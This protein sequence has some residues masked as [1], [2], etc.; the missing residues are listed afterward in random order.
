MVGNSS[1][2]GSV[3]CS[4]TSFSTSA[5]KTTSA[6]GL[7]RQ[8]GESKFSKEVSDSI[9]QIESEILAIK[10][11]DHLA[12]IGASHP[13]LIKKGHE[14]M[15]ERKESLSRPESQNND[16]MSSYVHG[17]RVFLSYDDP[18]FSP[19]SHG[20][21]HNNQ[22]SIGS[23][24]QNTSSFRGTTKKAESTN[25]MNRIACVISGKKNLQY[26]SGLEETS[27]SP[28]P[29]SCSSRGKQRKLAVIH[30][31]KDGHVHCKSADSDIGQ[32]DLAK[33]IFLYVDSNASGVSD[34]M[35]PIFMLKLRMFGRKDM[36]GQNERH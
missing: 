5:D 8:I 29:S 14:D 20:K 15:A 23:P 16:M 12:S 33:G 36:F 2:G 30:K 21:M 7:T 3:G 6:F 35:L 9:N 4:S 11:L 1:I 31:H 26:Q 27:S 10:L 25:A 24:N 28:I 34:M 32:H 18:G 13:A 17:L 22:T 19:T